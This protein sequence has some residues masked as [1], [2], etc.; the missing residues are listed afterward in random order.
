MSKFIT[1]TNRN[2]LPLFASCIDDAIAQDNQVRLIDLF[3]DSLKLPD[4]GF[5]FQFVENGRPAYHPSDLLKLFI[6]GYLNRMRSSRALE[7]ECARNIELMWLLKGLAPDHNTIANFRKD[8]PKA[9]ARVFRATVKMAA[10]FELIGGSL[11]AGDSTKL[12]AQNSKK[13]NFNPAKIERHIAY[14][15]ARL[16][17]YNTALAKED[18]DEVEKEKILKKVKKHSFQKQKYIEYQKIIDTTGVTQISTSD[19]DSRQIMTRNNISEVAYTVQTTVDAL[20]NIPI[21]FKV[22]NENDSKAMGGMLRRSKAI[23]GHNQFT[24]IYDKG[25][26]TGS[27]FHKANQL[28][29]AVLVAIPGVSAHAPDLAFDVEHFRYNSENDTYNCPANEVLISNGKWYNKTNGKSITKMK[30]YKTNACM[31]C[32]LFTKCTTNKKGRLIERSQ[33]ADLI[34]ENKVRIEN[35]YEVYRRRQAIV[36]HPYGVIKRQWDFY[37]IMT[38]K[39]IKHASAD[40]GLIFTAYNLKRIFNLIDQNELKQYLKTVALFFV[41]IKPLF[42]AFYGPFILVPIQFLFYKKKQIVI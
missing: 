14:I 9:I 32:A 37:Y 12:R 2:Q 10:Q 31:S 13:N 30:H 1:G 16:E 15:D 4:F 18:G 8:N 7:K 27:E 19:P 3:V 41:V 28:G 38:K 23:L 29:I 6:Y 25:Y 20:H 39:T 34:Y 22:T 40:V 42:K 11:V 21:D 24:A 17:E 36:E 26:H 5:D 33:Y 35:N